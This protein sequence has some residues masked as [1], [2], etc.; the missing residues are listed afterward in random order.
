MVRSHFQAAGCHSNVGAAVPAQSDRAAVVASTAGLASKRRAALCKGQG[1]FPDQRPGLLLTEDLVLHFQFSLPSSERLYSINTLFSVS[2]TELPFWT[3][4]WS[5]C[6]SLSA[7]RAGSCYWL[8]GVVFSLSS[9]ELLHPYYRSRSRTRL[10]APGC[11]Y[12]LKKR[13]RFKATSCLLGLVVC[14]QIQGLGS[15][16]GAT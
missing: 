12:V 3:P 4:T 6:S 10:Q 13:S 7:R 15:L 14:P 9:S 2:G 5:L 11:L 16:S 8:L 1:Q